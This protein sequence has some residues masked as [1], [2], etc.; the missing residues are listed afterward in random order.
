LTYGMA[1]ATGPRIFPTSISVF[2][3]LSGA[4]ADR[5]VMGRSGV[6][7]LLLDCTREGLRQGFRG[8]LWDTVLYAREWGFALEQVTIPV[9]LWHGT[10]DTIVPPS[11]VQILA[12]AL[13]HATVNLLEGEGHYSLPIEHCK[14]I[15]A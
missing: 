9:E 6:R 1:V 13:P 3:W 15:L 2:Q 11:H 14:A 12:D 10:A 5:V 8:P 4:P 7:G